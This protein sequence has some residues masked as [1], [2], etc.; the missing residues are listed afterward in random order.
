VITY[1]VTLETYHHVQYQHWK[2]M[3][4]ECPGSVCNHI[5]FAQLDSKKIAFAHIVSQQWARSFTF[6]LEKKDHPENLYLT[7]QKCNSSLG[8]KFLDGLLRMRLK[9]GEQLETG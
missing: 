8:D 4:Y 1:N 7:C 5:K 3:N 2:K 9:E 6:L